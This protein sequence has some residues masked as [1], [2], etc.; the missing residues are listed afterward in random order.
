MKIKITLAAT[1]LL[2][3]FM[4]I[5]KFNMNEEESFFHK[6]VTVEYSTAN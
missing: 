1:M 3:G 5:D 4:L 2:I 6:S